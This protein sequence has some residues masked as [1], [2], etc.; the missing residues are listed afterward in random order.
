MRSERLDRLDDVGLYRS[1]EELDFILRVFGGCSAREIQ[2]QTY[3]LKRTS[4]YVE[5]QL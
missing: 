1:G 3:I 2:D 4:S 5:N